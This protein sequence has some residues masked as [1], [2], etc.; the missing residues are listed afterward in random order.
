MANRKQYVEALKVERENLA[1]R[2]ES[3][4][5]KRRLGEVDEQLGQFDDE[6][7]TGVIEAAVPGPISAR[8]KAAPKARKA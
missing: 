2:H 7:D 8:K 4:A 3:P 6:P 5:I 1:R